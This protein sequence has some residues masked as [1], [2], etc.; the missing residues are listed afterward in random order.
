MKAKIA[1]G[2][3]QLTT[4]L[5]HHPLGAINA[6]LV[7]DG[8]TWT[9]IDSGLPRLICL[10]SLLRQ[11]AEI[12]IRI[13]DITRLVGTHGHP[14]HFGLAARIKE[15][16]GCELAL[17]EREIPLLA[18]YVGGSI[19]S[20]SEGTVRDWLVMNG[21]PG[22][23]IPGEYYTYGEELPM[24]IDVDKA[25]KGGE[26]LTAG[27][28]DL[29]VIWTPG[30]SPGHICLYD[31]SRGILF[32]GDHILPSISPNVSAI[33]G[34][35]ENPL[36]EFISSL[37]KFEEL[38]DDI[39]VLPAHK[40]PFSGLRGRIGELRKHHD[41]R[42]KNVIDVLGKHE[43]TAFQIATGMEWNGISG[44]LTGDRLT[45]TERMLSLGETLAH[46]EFLRSQGRVEKTLKSSVITWKAA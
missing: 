19:L 10:D 38:T 23:E 29:E 8:T 45:Y 14:D 4:P 1:D 31:R 37:G 40:S 30:H 15:L 28:T 11:I 24:P 20:T 35:T 34:Q 13:E 12:G 26:R 16:S 43:R 5:P 46:L 41:Q 9:L 3:Y 22:N 21:F 42:S 2:V 32:T 18:T 44:V 33:P 17:H 36:S 6:Y 39:I 7:G 27:S 25:L